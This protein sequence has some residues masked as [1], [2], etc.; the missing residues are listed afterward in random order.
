M[1]LFYDL[2]E[3]VDEEAEGVVGPAAIRVLE[4]V[5]ADPLV[6]H[7]ARAVGRAGRGFHEVHSD[8][9]GGTPEFGE[10]LAV[11][12]AVVGIFAC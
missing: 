7:A 9:E 5:E 12:E 6:T 10:G 2:R 11:A 3:K 8:I 4:G 1:V